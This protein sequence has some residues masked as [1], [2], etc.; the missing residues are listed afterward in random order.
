MCS[1][2]NPLSGRERHLVCL[3]EAGSCL[4]R[5]LSVD[6][7]DSEQRIY[8]LVVV[9]AI[10]LGELFFCASLHRRLSERGCTWKS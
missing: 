9:V 10:V 5:G 6:Y 1:Y 3:D 4:L 2:M 7:S 8:L